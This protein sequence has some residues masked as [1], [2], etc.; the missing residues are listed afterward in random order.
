MLDIMLEEFPFSSLWNSGLF[1]F[2]AFTAVIYL[3]ILP[4]EKN[5]PLWKS[6]VFFLGLVTL[7][8]STAS[9]L[10]I[11]GR[12]QFS[13]HIV[14]I[15]L[16]CY[17][18]PPLLII[19]MNRKILDY[20]FKIR[21]F[22]KVINFSTKP[23]VTIS[24][25][26]FALYAYHHPPIFDQARVDLY[27]NY[28]YLF[29]MFLTAILLWVPIISQKST[30]KLTAIYHLICVAFSM[31][32]GGILL[33]SKDIL[34]QAYTDLTTFT[35]ALEVCL[36]TGQTLSPELVLML[37]PFEPIGEQHIGGVIWLAAGLIIFSISL[38]VNRKIVK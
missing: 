12:I 10:N 30:K 16:L 9:P 3:F 19:G 35:Q 17:I 13:A 14:Q 7:F 34:Y 21:Y 23:F 20:A 2:I 8:F 1:L 31:P 32:L 37:L 22:A 6:T 25:F 18:A 4:Q 28:L 24:L 15:V 5:H 38:L 27:G 29:F 11:V 36:P 26:F 33:F